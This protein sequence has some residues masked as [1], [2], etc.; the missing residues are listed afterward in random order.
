MNQEMN[1]RL[2]M[3]SERLKKEYQA[4]KIILY[5]SYA[6]GEAT[7]DSDVDLSHLRKSVF[8]KGWRQ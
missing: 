1:K 8:L 2:H 6:T 7:E 4:E 3:I 5:G